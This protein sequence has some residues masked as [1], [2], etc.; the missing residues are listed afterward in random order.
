M[1]ID[2]PGYKKVLYIVFGIHIFMFIVSFNAALFGNSS[3]VLADSIDFIGD[4]A[5]YASSMYVINKSRAIRAYLSI[6][7]AITMLA[8]SLLVIIYT[9]FKINDGIVPN[10]EIMGASGILGIIS[11]LI[12]VYYLFRFRKGD[13]NQISSWVCTI[14]DLISNTLTVIAAYFVMAT[15]SIFPDIL[16]AFL[17]VGVAIYGA[18][19]ILK[20]ATK[21]IREV[22][23]TEKLETT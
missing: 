14:N 8:F 23:D 2:L 21:E 22:G 5:S 6:A 12:C 9:I 19:T 10:Y 11:H 17:I 4:A 18:I 20:Q 1:P 16:A 3:S 15:N 13:S 7:K